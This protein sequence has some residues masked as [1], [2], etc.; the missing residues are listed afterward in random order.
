[1]ADTPITIRPYQYGD[2]EGINKLFNRIFH[3]SRTIE[4]W[5]WKFRENPASKDPAEWIVVA[6]RDGKVI[7]H[8]ASLATEMKYDN[9]VIKAG[10]PVDTIIDPSAKAGMKLIG[11]LYDMHVKHNNGIALLGFGF[12]NETA[13]MVGKR[14]LGYKDLGEMVQLFKRLGLRVSLK[15]RFPWCPGRIIHLF[16]HISKVFYRFAIFLRGFDTSTVVKS[17]DAF[18]ERVNRFWNSIKDRY[19]IMTVRN[20]SY[21]NWRYKSKQYRIFVGEKSEELAGYAV[22]KIENSSD[23]RVGYI[24]DIFSRNDKIDSLLAGC[25]KFFIKQDVD[26]ILCG[27]LRHDSLCTLLKRMGFR[28]HKE[29]KPIQ[30]V[31]APLTEEVD[32][33]YLLN[34]ENWHL[35]YGD[36][37]GF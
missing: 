36:T 19:K 20:M 32:T 29:I 6:E 1:M 30:V 37:D 7:G 24:M 11:K 2:E 31:F 34:P 28:E 14:F 4:E 23:V 33:E 10:Q 22:T 5:N 18:D 35:T 21:L 8:Y 12:P 27:L 17:V 9:R 16:H 3:K 13:Y 15:R 25:L 26:Y